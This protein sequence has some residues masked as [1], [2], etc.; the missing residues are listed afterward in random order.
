MGR[1]FN[2]FYLVG[3]VARSPMFPSPQNLSKYLCKRKFPSII[4][5]QTER[6]LSGCQPV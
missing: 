5:L 1:R 4:D 6:E 3:G 2:L